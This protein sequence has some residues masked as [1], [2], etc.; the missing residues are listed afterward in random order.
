M[1]KVVVP[2]GAEIAVYAFDDTVGFVLNVSDI[3]YQ[4]EN[5]GII[6]TK[7]RGSDKDVVISEKIN[8]L[9][10]VAIWR[11]CALRKQPDKR[12]CSQWR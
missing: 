8:N 2:D 9:P 11:L 7:Y 3:E 5:G 4:E 10:I 1:R 6:I 12:C